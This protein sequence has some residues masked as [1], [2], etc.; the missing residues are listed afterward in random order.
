MSFAIRRGPIRDMPEI[1]PILECDRLLP[2]AV[3]TWII[4]PGLF[5]MTISIGSI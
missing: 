3:I 1:C 5:D 2:G 4:G